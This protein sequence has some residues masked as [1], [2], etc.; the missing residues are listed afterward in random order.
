LGGRRA[1]FILGWS[2]DKD[3][4]GMA[5]ALAPVA[6]TVIATRAGS[7]RAAVAAEV[8]AAMRHAAPALQV[9]EAA[10]VTAALAQARARATAEQPVVVCGSLFLVGE[11][12]VALGLA[13]ADP[14]AL[15]DPV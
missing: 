7:E 1:H 15:Q 13:T 12:R 6:C 4:A 10:D 9:D 11:A 2:A 14:L 3:G 8:A 5:R